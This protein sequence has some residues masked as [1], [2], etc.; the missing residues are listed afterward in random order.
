M[1]GH[2]ASSMLLTIALG[3]KGSQGQAVALHQLEEKI[4]ALGLAGFSIAEHELYPG[5]QR[6]RLYLALDEIQ[7]ASGA[8][9][10]AR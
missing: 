2:W 9:T 7:E 4:A 10:P 6:A 1:S 3:R 8:F 5:F